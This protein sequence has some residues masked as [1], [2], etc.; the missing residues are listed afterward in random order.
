M[1]HRRFA[2]PLL[3]C[4]GAL[5]ACVTTVPIRSTQPGRVFVGATRHVVI[6]DGQGRRSAREL[7]TI[8]LMNQARAQ[9]YFTFEDRSEDGLDV[10]VAGR[11]ASIEGGSFTLEHGAAGLRVDVLEWSAHRDSEQ[12]H[13][14]DSEGNPYVRT[15]A[16]QAGTALL[17][18]TLFDHEGRAF[19]AEAEYEGRFVTRDTQMSRDEVIEEAARQA[20]GQFLADITPVQVVSR[21]RLDDEDPGQEPILQVARAGNI[22]QAAHDMGLYLQQ[23]PYSASAAYNL[24]VFLEAMGRY[25]EALETYDRALSL[26]YQ[27]LYS[28]ARAECARRLAA[29]EALQG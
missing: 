14:H 25:G 18:M 26:G 9:G 8:E 20:V 28:S 17:A 10:R 24:A 16:V 19:L 7:V 22:A 21:V 4:A 6:V 12:V 29:A 3:F 23:N 1:S 5:A 2:N 15:I 11:R 27:D 13:S